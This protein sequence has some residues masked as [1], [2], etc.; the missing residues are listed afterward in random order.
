MKKIIKCF[1]Y[2]VTV[3]LNHEKIKKDPQRI[4]KISPFLNK[5]KWERINFPPEKDD[6]QKFEENNVR[7]ALNIFYFKKIYILLMFQNITQIV[8]N[9]LFFQ[10]FQMEKN[11]KLS[12]KNDGIILQS[13]TTLIDI[14]RRNNFSIL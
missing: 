7:I 10:L 4:T 8:K 6:W 5:Y 3:T 1:Q 9:K 12:S 13:K 2:S 14:I 11:V